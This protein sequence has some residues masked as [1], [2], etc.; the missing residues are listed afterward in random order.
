MPIDTVTAGQLVQYVFFLAITTA[1]GWIVKVL[2]SIRDD[3]KEVK[4]EVM[5]LNNGKDGLISKVSGLIDRMD[6]VDVR[7]VKADVL[8]EIEKELGPA[9]LRRLRDRVMGNAPPSPASHPEP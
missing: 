2:P 8:T 1:V 4:R 3:V 6:A 9:E 7:H 5:G